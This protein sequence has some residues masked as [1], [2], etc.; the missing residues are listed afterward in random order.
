MTSEH[1]SGYISKNPFAYAEDGRL[2]AVDEIPL[3]KFGSRMPLSCP[4]CNRALLSVRRR[5]RE[6]GQ[7]RMHHFSHAKARSGEEAACTGF[8]ESAAHRMSKSMFEEAASASAGSPSLALPPIRIADIFP[9]DRKLA[10]VPYWA[11]QRSRRTF[12]CSDGQE[13]EYPWICAQGIRGE[14][15]AAYV[16]HDAK[17]KFIKGALVPD[18]VV[19]VANP[20]ESISAKPTLA[21][22][23]EIC[24]THA[25]TLEDMLS[26]EREPLIDAV[27][28]IDVSEISGITAEDA[29]DGALRE[30]LSY[31]LFESPRTRQW[32]YFRHASEMFACTC[33]PVSIISLSAGTTTAAAYARDVLGA[34][35]DIEDPYPRFA[36]C[37]ISP[38]AAKTQM[39]LYLNG[40]Y[41]YDIESENVI[42]LG[43][44][45]DSEDEDAPAHEDAA[46]FL[47]KHAHLIATLSKTSSESDEADEAR[48]AFSINLSDA[49][50]G[51]G[52]PIE[53]MRDSADFLSSLDLL[54][55]SMIEDMRSAI[56]DA[57]A[58]LFNISP[59]VRR[60]LISDCT[61]SLKERLGEDFV[62][63]EPAELTEIGT[64]ANKCMQDMSESI[65]RMTTGDVS[66]NED[67]KR[68]VF[69]SEPA[70]S[71]T[72]ILLDVNERLGIARISSEVFGVHIKT[73]CDPVDAEKMMP[74]LENE[75]CSI[76]EVD[77]TDMLDPTSIMEEK[78]IEDI[79]IRIM[80]GADDHRKYL[81]DGASKML[82]RYAIPHPVLYIEADKITPDEKEML[83]GIYNETYL[84]HPSLKLKAIARPPKIEY[85]LVRSYECLPVSLF[86][87]A[88]DSEG[89]D[90]AREWKEL[91]ALIADLDHS[92]RAIEATSKW[93]EDV[94]EMFGI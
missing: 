17:S 30:K 47:G 4:E 73:G 85:S 61:A 39:Q 91:D 82:C 26:Y 56:E 2:I 15:K 71:C 57:E 22:A 54:A 51:I 21:I 78:L 43:S 13:C 90:A 77:V 16:E 53:K 14:I 9:H 93:D 80:R 24:N 28:E 37:S 89:A 94:E 36:S 52:R 23:I 5:D 3:D 32:L 42:L 69:S 49:L 76:I 44:Q 12:H 81:H 88:R 75:E 27:M 29:A 84:A 48:P 70:R 65:F 50:S 72:D 83:R 66:S 55:A 31:L 63:P 18:M 68:Q 92:M 20:Y 45:G 87:A 6:T 11:S 62:L 38:H 60:A 79:A 64:Y 40:E 7:W 67:D 25:K 58:T 74:N 35:S 46:T 86:L 34:K 41:P 19:E 59:S 33:A 1:K 8:G 10:G